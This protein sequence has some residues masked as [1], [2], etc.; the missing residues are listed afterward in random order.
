MLSLI[1]YYHAAAEGADAAALRNRTRVN[2]AR[3][4]RRVVH[5]L[6]AGV[7]V[8]AMTGK[9]YAR[10]LTVRAL[11][12]QNAHGIQVGNM[13]AKGAAN[14]F[15]G[16]ALSYQRTLSIQVIHILGPVFNGAVAQLSIF[17][18][19][20]LYT[21]SM[22]I[23]HIIFRRTAALDKVQICALIHDNQGMLKL[24]CALRVKAEVGLQGNGHLHSLRY[25]HKGAAGPNCAVEGCKF[26]IRGRNELHKMLL[27]HLRIRSVQSAFHIGIN[28]ALLLN[29]LAHIMVHKL[30]VILRAHACQAGLLGLGNAQTL[31]G[32][33]NIVGN[34]LPFALHLSI[35]AHIG[36]NIIHIEA[37]NAGP[38]LHHGRLVINF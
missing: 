21:A 10:E 1:S 4:V 14:P 25:I 5:H 24:A 27:H 31:E 15:N 20:K 7:Q 34:I 30:A 6:T 32:V 37:F 26:M 18:N 12:I 28:H 36:H 16:A 23:G 2:E 29:L 19:K 3:S 13:G 9:G 33:L 11:T 38:P 22:Q 17:S 8:L 35:G